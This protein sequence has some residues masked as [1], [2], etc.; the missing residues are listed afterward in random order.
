LI[1]GV[2]LFMSLIRAGL[3]VAQTIEAII[4]TVCD[5]LMTL[6]NSRILLTGFP[7]TAR[8]KWPPRPASALLSISWTKHRVWAMARS[9]QTRKLCAV[10]VR[11]P[12]RTEKISFSG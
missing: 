7:I 5:T 11:F 4:V 2:L 9:M 6:L 12:G 8:V 1:L 10:F 3:V